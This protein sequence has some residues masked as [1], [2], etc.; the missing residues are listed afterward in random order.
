MIVG[1][2]TVWLVIAVSVSTVD[3]EGRGRGV[4]RVV[5]NDLLHQLRPRPTTF[6]SVLHASLAA[7]KLLLLLLMLVLKL[8]LLLNVLSMCVPIFTVVIGLLIIRSWLSL[9]RP[10]F[11]LPICLFRH[12]KSLLDFLEGVLKERTDLVAGPAWFLRWLLLLRLFLLFL[13]LLLL[14]LLLL[15]ILLIRRLLVPIAATIWLGGCP[16]AFLLQFLLYYQIFLHHLLILLLFH[17]I[18]ILHFLS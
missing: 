10:W 9:H 2:T 17:L 7:K 6:Y 3:R 8:L 4:V 14:L 13:L 1:P 15:V 16:V 12:R 5:K 11:A 18:L